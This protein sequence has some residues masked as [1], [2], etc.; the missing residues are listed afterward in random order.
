MFWQRKHVQWGFRGAGKTLVVTDG[1]SNLITLRRHVNRFPFLWECYPPCTWKTSGRYGLFQGK[2]YRTL[3]IS[4]FPLLF[5]LLEEHSVAEV[6]GLNTVDYGSMNKLSMNYYYYIN[7][8]I[9]RMTYFLLNN[10]I[11][12]IA[13]ILLHCIIHIIY[14]DGKY[15]IQTGSRF[16]LLFLFRGYKEV[17]HIKHFLVDY[18]LYIVQCKSF[19]LILNILLFL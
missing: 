13:H 12:I 6:L 8:F 19:I 5:D 10:L 11:S 16:N 7:T 15:S 2:I 18:F 3:P 14:S 4:P 1:R 9:E 17:I